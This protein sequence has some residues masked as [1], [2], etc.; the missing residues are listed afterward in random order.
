[1]RIVSFLYLNGHGFD[2]EG[3]NEDRKGKVTRFDISGCIRGASE[4]NP[5]RA[6]DPS[7]REI[8]KREKSSEKGV[9]CSA[10]EEKR[11][12]K[13]RRKGQSLYASQTLMTLK[14]QRLG[15]STQHRSSSA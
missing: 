1:M 9:R 13:R 7:D 14:P 5:S 4:G 8:L 11:Y 15:G 3:R 6:G 2:G 10:E 12:R